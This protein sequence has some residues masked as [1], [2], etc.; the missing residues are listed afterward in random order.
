VNCLKGCAR[1]QSLNSGNT[2]ITPNFNLK[3]GLNL[4]Q[5]RDKPVIVD[6]IVLL[7]HFAT[8]SNDYLFMSI[9]HVV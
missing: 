5:F 6:E 7:R 3:F 8:S 4:S 9:L 1:L 2:G